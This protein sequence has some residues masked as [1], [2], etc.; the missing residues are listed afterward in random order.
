MY[1]LRMVK[2]LRDRCEPGT[3]AYATQVH[4][5]YLLRMR[6]NYYG[7]PIIDYITVMEAFDT[8]PIWTRIKD[9]T[10]DDMDCDWKMEIPKEWVKSRHIGFP[11]DR[12][13]QCRYCIRRDLRLGI[14]CALRR[15]C[16]APFMGCNQFK[17]IIQDNNQEAKASN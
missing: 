6:V 9:P 2:K 12:Q 4:D 10:G 14:Y 8:K 16:V 5:G 15:K 11:E 17:P 13:K 7:D 1:F 3:Y